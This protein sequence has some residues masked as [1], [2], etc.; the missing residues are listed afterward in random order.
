MWMHLES[1][2]AIHLVYTPD[3]R[4]CLGLSLEQEKS[5]HICQHSAPE[6]AS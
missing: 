5:K 2:E 3:T 6:A 4:S 1:E